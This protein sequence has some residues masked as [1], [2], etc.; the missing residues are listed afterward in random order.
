M[1]CCIRYS[2]S[3]HSR[4]LRF[5][6]SNLF[7]IFDYN[8]DNQGSSNAQVAKKQRT[9]KENAIRKKLKGRGLFEWLAEESCPTFKFAA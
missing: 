5:V 2:S 1:H 8:E 9:A 6:A 7:E 4:A 3:R